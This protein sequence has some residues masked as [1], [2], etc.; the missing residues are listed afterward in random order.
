[1]A[2][3]GALLVRAD[4]NERIG[5]GHVMRCMALAQAWQ[6]EG[7]T[8]HFVSGS[9][10]PTLDARLRAEGMGTSR[11]DVAPGGAAD[12][13][14][15]ISLAREMEVAWVVVDG[16]QFDASYQRA[17]KE[18]GL[19]LLFLDDYGHATHYYADLV[20]NQNIHANP[21][22]YTRREP[23]TALLL[24][25]R[26]ALLR[27][28]FQP[29]R[30]W[31]RKIPPVARRV[32]VTLGG[33]DP[34]N[35]TLKVIQALGLVKADS[36]EAVVVVGGNNPHHGEL[37]AATRHSSFTIRLERNVT[38]MAS[39]MAWADVA[40][41]A[42]GSTCWELAFLGLPSIVLALVDNQDA[43]AKGLYNAGV[44]TSLD[45]QGDVMVLEMSNKLEKLIQRKAA[46]AKM[47]DLGQKLVDGL[48]A[49][50]AALEL[51]SGTRA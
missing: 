49:H 16:Y 6:E 5:T 20:L 3:Q 26:Y 12:A 10:A 43:I 2:E 8:S 1:M 13:A 38:N 17:I 21:S 9:V 30:G 36:L 27:R 4:A 32:L 19:R 46:R 31:Q 29:W 51:I 50:R 35:L 33:A 34:N 18:A 14:Q 40:V 7:G 44:V 22:L 24:G 25:T 15:T 37:Q 42:G 23:D 48:G 11:L 28:E 41:S 39:L 47:C 45:R